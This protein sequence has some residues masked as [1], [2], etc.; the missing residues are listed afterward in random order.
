MAHHDATRSASSGRRDRVI[1]TA[2]IPD[3]GNW[4]V[5][6]KERRG[7]AVGHVADVAQALGQ[8]A[9]GTIHQLCT[10]EGLGEEMG[11]EL[12]GSAGQSTQAESTHHDNGD[13]R[14]LRML[15]QTAQGSE[16]IAAGHHDIQD[17]QLRILRES[18]I[19]YRTAVRGEYEVFKP[20]A[21]EGFSEQLPHNRFIISHK[22]LLGVNGMVKVG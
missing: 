15:L 11:G 16:T 13:G 10:R 22:N 18:Q 20:G 7:I 4:F 6:S 17:D 2:T 8:K 3:R 21:A 14:G 1:K 19:K 12:P 9:A 5:E